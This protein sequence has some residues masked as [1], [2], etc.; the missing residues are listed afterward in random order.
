MWKLTDLT[1]EKNNPES[2]FKKFEH[3]VLEKNLNFIVARGKCINQGAKELGP[4]QVAAYLRAYAACDFSMIALL[5]ESPKT[6][7]IAANMEAD[8]G[9][10]RVE[11]LIDFNQEATTG[12]ASPFYSK[13]LGAFA[14]HFFALHPQMGQLWF[15][16][17]IENMVGSKMTVH[18]MDSGTAILR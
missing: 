13:L 9:L 16:F 17:A 1:H 6:P 5:N 3:Y 2:L 12:T 10:A 18:A 8:K 7:F 15:P 14:T 4:H 11:Y